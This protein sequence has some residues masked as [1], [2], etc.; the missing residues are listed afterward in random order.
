[1]ALTPA[2]STQYANYAAVPPVLNDGRDHGKLRMAYAKLTY[3]A[4]GTG[5]AQM[6]RMPAGRVRIFPHISRNTTTQNA[7]ASST[8]SVGLGAYTKADGSAQSASTTAL[9]NAAA[10]GAATVDA[11][12][13]STAGPV[14]LESKQGVDV[15]IT[16]GTA[17]SPASGDHHLLI[18]Y[19]LAG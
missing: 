9:L 3:T 8:L 16:W 10:V 19:V 18:A 17:N 4:G 2:V 15:T 6:I 12:L 11:A 14:E 13:T 5:T 1:M 7:S